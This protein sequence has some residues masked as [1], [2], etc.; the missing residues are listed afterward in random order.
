MAA[1][2]AAAEAVLGVNERRRRRC[3]KVA[4]QSATEAVLSEGEDGGK[5]RW[6]LPVSFYVALLKTVNVDG[7]DE[8]MYGIKTVSNYEI[9]YVI[10][11]SVEW[12]H[13]T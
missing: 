4:Q 1:A 8:L 5:R 2:A 6:L 11:V 3:C 7:N 13:L 10:G 9:P 12:R